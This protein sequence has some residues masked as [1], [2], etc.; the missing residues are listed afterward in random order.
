MAE[1]ADYE[2]YEN[3]DDSEVGQQ[4]D[5]NFKRPYHENRNDGSGYGPPKRRRQEGGIEMRCLI[6]SKFAGA[7]IGKG[8]MNIKELRESFSAQVFL[9]DA[10]A[11][12]RVLKV[13]GSPESC[14]NVL[15]KVLPQIEDVRQDGED[16]QQDQDSFQQRATIKLLVHQSQAG[17]I[18]GTKGTRIKELR[19]K[20]GATIKVHQD[21]AGNSTDR[22]CNI[23]G[24]HEVISNCITM[25][26]EL[27]ENIPPKGPVFDFDP[28][29]EQQ[30]GGGGYDDYSGGFGGGYEGYRGGFGG[31]FSRPPRGGFG[32][33]GFRGGRGG[34]GGGRGGRGRYG[35][36]DGGR[37]RGGR[38]GYRGGRGGTRGRG[39]GGGNGFE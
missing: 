28:N 36:R 32:G 14:G 26:M 38:G 37:G 13:K 18:I 24:S 30:F 23:S 11:P 29:M 27:L 17:G 21:C 35:D 31:G 25:I 22:I 1:S 5:Q 15:L 9:P 16:Y 7:I 8:G 6:P 12:E 3:Y 33:G 19:E 10:Q 20:T 39:N 2:S 34:F 4:T